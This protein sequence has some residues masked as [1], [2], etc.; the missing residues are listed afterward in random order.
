M[1]LLQTDICEKEILEQSPNLLSILLIDRTLSSE[2]C[3]VNIFWA[4]NNYANLGAGYQY[5][6]PI[7]I[8]AITGKNG[9]VIKGGIH[10][11]VSLLRNPRKT[12]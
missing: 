7:T 12:Q 1:R 3:Q 2:N 8:D 9:D 4:T 5:E 10:F 11:S 6:D